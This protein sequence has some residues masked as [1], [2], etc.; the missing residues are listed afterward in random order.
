MRVASGRPV[1]LYWQVEDDTGEVLE[2]ADV[3]AS[4]VDGLG[5]A[6][7]GVTG[8][9]AL[10][11]A[12]NAGVWQLDLPAQTVLDRLTVTWSGTAGGGTYT[13][14]VV[15]DVVGQRI[16]PLARLRADPVC[17]SLRP[18]DLAVVLDVV[19]DTLDDVL[20]F[21]VVA[22]GAWVTLDRFGYTGWDDPIIVGVDPDPAVAGS[23]LLPGIR[24]PIRVVAGTR[25]DVALTSDE[26]AALTVGSSGLRWGY[27]ASWPAGLYRLHI[28]HGYANPPA[29]VRQA[30]LTMCRYAARRVPKADAR[31]ATSLPERTA[32]LTTEGATIVFARPGPDQPTG[33]PEVDAVIV[34][35]RATTFL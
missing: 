8:P 22:R 9:T 1:R 11:G 5:V 4:V 20:R 21:P 14:Q 13:E 25:G 34:R 23:S 31:S 7:P 15:V 10:E 16:V 17:Q 29:D 2:L 28:E 6:V 27:G 24:R 32:S 19:E 26:L 33:L 18:A 30:A 35:R 3:T 12:E